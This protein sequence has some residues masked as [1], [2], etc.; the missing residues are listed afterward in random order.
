ML[1]VNLFL[2]SMCSN[3]GQCITVRSI[4]YHPTV[5]SLHCLYASLINSNHAFK[6]CLTL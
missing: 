5:R 3:L 1:Q 2:R 4:C 6:P